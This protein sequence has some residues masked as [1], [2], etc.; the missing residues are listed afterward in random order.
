MCQA[1]L[2]PQCIQSTPPPENDGSHSYPHVTDGETE[3]QSSSARCPRSP[4]KLE[5]DLRFIPRHLTSQLCVLTYRKPTS[6]PSRPLARVSWNPR[7][8]S[9]QRSSQHISEITPCVQHVW[10]NFP[11]AIIFTGIPGYKTSQLGPGGL[12][13]ELP[14]TECGTPPP[15]ALSQKTGGNYSI[16]CGQVEP[17]G[18]P[19][20]LTPAEREL[21]QAG[22][23]PWGWVGSGSV[24][25]HPCAPHHSKDGHGI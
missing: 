19:P 25:T 16:L 3:S 7:A 23:R 6:Q 5:A 20:H 22:V 17:T 21:G 9:P 4:K 14:G 18:R 24:Y 15:A 10:V 11:A 1:H 8:S 13:M 2:Q 12:S